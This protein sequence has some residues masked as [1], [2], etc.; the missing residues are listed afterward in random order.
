MK[1][2]TERCGPLMLGLVVLLAGMFCLAGT[3]VEARDYD[4][5]YVTENGG[6]SGA[7]SDDPAGS[8]DLRTII[9]VSADSADQ[10]RVA[11]GTYKPTSA[12]APDSVDQAQSFTLAEGVTVQ[13]GWAPD[14]S[15]RNPD[16]YVTTLSGNIG[17]PASDDNSYHVLFCSGVASEDNIGNKTRLQGVTIAWGVAGGVLSGDVGGEVDSDDYT[18]HWGGGILLSGDSSPIFEDCTVSDNWANIGGGVYC[19]D[20][21]PSYSGCTVSGNTAVGLEDMGEGTGGGMVNNLGSHPT[22]TD[23]RFEDNRATLG[24]GMLN[25]G[26]SR[27]SLEGCTFAGNSAEL[28]GGMGN[29]DSDAVVSG[30]VF[31]ENRAVVGAGLVNASCSPD[32]TGSTFAENEAERYGGGM[33]ND[34]GHPTVEGCTFVDNRVTYSGEEQPALERMSR[35]AYRRA[36]SENPQGPFGA[37]GGMANE[38]S[39]PIVVNCTFSGNWANFGG[40]AMLNMDSSSPVVTS[41]TFTGNTEA[42]TQEIGS[43]M[44]NV[45]SSSPMVTNCI[46]ADEMNNEIVSWFL[47]NP[48]VTYS[49]VFDSAPNELVGTSS[50]NTSADPLLGP[51]A[52][53]GGPT[54]TCTIAADSP[55]WNSASPDIMIAASNDILDSDISADQRGEPRPFGDGYDMGAFE[56][57]DWSYAITTDWTGNGRISPDDPLVAR[58]GRVSLDVSPD[59]GYRIT[60]LESDDVSLMGEVTDPAA[61]HTVVFTDVQAN[62]TLSASF[63]KRSYRITAIEGAHGSVVPSGDIRLSFDESQTFEIA[64]DSGYDIRVVSV[65]GRGVGTPGSYTF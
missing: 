47:S 37:G 32:I 33:F 29:D 20:S 59:R 2:S 58:G 61:G 44:F 30:C 56:L 31:S 60:E 11:E 46:L 36:L 53:N 10:V 27:P 40:G 17:A 62:H 5:W 34:R 55:A 25:Y 35:Q 21:S 3:P 51:L 54:E 49:V 16:R 9:E 22:L 64:P 14:F 19:Y 43:G 23:C 45:M 26:G 42:S 38:R 57:Q 7:T 8:W 63:G 4:Y 15:E 6:G 48:R 41:C 50:H 39:S 18:D 12:D 13:G 24:G 65:D 52:D 28:G 1:G